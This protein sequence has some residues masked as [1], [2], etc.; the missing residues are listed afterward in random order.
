MVTLT[1]QETPPRRNRARAYHLLTLT[2]LVRPFGNLCLAW[3]MKH[4]A[5][6]MSINP[7][8]YLQAMLNPFVFA[9]IVLLVLAL[10]T[11]MALLSVADLSFVVPLSGAGY[12]LSS[13]LGRFFLR[14]HISVVGWVGTLLIVLGT[15]VV[16]SS[17]EKT[18]PA[19]E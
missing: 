5:Q 13:L 14:E 4:L 15:I 11:R 6:I 17:S 12:V 7:V 18:T 9:G 16:G 8:A 2:L 1:R 10:L 19:T 3:G